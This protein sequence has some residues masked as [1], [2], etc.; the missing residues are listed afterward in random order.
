MSNNELKRDKSGLEE[1]IQDKEKEYIT[2]I[3]ALRQSNS[4]SSKSIKGRI[5]I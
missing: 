1:Q 4:I 2:E 5:S 3:S